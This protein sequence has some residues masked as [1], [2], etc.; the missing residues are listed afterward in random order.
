MLQSH[1]N[2]PS[3]RDSRNQPRQ[4]YFQAA[5]DPLSPRFLINLVAERQS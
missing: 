1:E 4:R 3:P 2:L 5:C